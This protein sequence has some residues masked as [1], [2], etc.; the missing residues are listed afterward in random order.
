MKTRIFVIVLIVLVAGGIG[1]GMWWA[2]REHQGPAVAVVL[3]GNVDIRQVELAFNSNARIEQLRVHEGDRV[4]KGELL[5]VLDTRRLRIT[6]AQAEAQV[7]AQQQVVARN[8]AGS[9]PEEIRKARADAQAARVDAMNAERLYQRQQQLVA[10]NFISQQQADNA[11]ADADAARAKLNAVEETL[12]LVVAG[13]RKE[14]KEAAKATLRAYEEALAV[15]RRDLEEA[16]LYAPSDGIIQNRIL[17]PGDMASPQ[18]PVFTLALDDP[19]WVRAYLSEPDLGRIHPGTRAEI[20]TDSYP[21]KRYRGWVG[22]VSPTA[23][24]TPKTVETREVRT[25][26]VYQIRVFVCAPHNELRL[27]MPATVTIPLDQAPAAQSA[28]PCKSPA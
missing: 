27:G 11:K 9:R 19:L 10:R 15:A 16:S 26:L 17:E 2:Q 8:E 1:G 14:D 7:A 28:D 4:R 5:A 3:H 22:F 20:T 23:E 12:K 21:G 24:F 13:P 25:S 18:K 6:V